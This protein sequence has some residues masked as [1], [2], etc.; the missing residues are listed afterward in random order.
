M[1][2]AHIFLSL[3][4]LVPAGG[5]ALPGSSF[6]ASQNDCQAIKDHASE[7]PNAAAAAQICSLIESG[8]LRNCVGRI[9]P[10]FAPR[11][12]SSTFPQDMDWPGLS[13]AAQHSRLTR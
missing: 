9:A 13:K 12:G 11:S 5:P 4:L 6:Q 10:R 3:L 1:S 2:K 8:R 7:N